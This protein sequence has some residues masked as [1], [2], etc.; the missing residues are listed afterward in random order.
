M[1]LV[2]LIAEDESLVDLVQDEKA[3]NKLKKIAGKFNVL[4]F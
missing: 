3:K 4:R 1:S 2:S